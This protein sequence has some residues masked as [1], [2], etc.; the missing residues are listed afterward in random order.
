MRI[1]LCYPVEPQHIAQIRAAAPQAEVH[2][3]GQAHV[4]EELFRCDIFCGH[5]K[6][7][8]DWDGIVVQGRLKWIQS[9]AAGLDHLL[10]PS[11][12]QSPI[13]VSS[14]SGVLSDQVAEH[15]IALV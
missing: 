14:A 5:P 4:A 10:V 13:I 12:V 2:D 8:I 9:S 6:V 1:V 7:P 15:T 11:V 3:A